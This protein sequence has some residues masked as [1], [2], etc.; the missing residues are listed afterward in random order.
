MKLKPILGMVLFS[1]FLVGCVSIPDTDRMMKRMQVGQQLAKE[2]DVPAW[3]TQR[4]QITQSMGDRVF[5]KD[6]NRVFDSLTV[7]IAGM[8]MTVDN[9]ERQS[10]YIAARGQLLP[11][12]RAKQLRTEEMT[13][14]CRAKGY[15]PSLLEN[16]G[17][18]DMIDPE[19]FGMQQRGGTLTISLVKQTEKQTKVKLRFN[20]V[21][22]PPTLEEFYKA[23]WP[24]LDKQIFLDKGTD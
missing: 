8:G 11:P 14:W 22:Y 16:R 17:K 1:L 20:G 7:A 23:I 9:M 21:Y 2:P 18:Y 13:A 24:G 10:G 3:Y 19:M 5:D 15:D 4:G 6:F 12:E